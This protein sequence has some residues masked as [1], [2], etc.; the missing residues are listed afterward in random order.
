M[1]LHVFPRCLVTKTHRDEKVSVACRPPV[2]AHVLRHDLGKKTD[3][4]YFLSIFILCRIFI[5]QNIRL[6]YDA[7][8]TPHIFL[9]FTLLLPSES[10]NSFKIGKKSILQELSFIIPF[11][12]S[13]HFSST[14][15]V[16]LLV[17]M[18]LFFQ[19][20]LFLCSIF[21]VRIVL[22]FDT[23]VFFE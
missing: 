12:V 22:F 17:H 4:E 14:F 10:H 23:H 5:P 21:H 7:I 9:F 20:T 8:S 1:F 3:M 2:R 13:Y 15:S 18:I 6:V 11:L 19:P 16:S